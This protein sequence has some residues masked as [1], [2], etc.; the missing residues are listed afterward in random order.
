MLQD[1]LQWRARS[2]SSG[3]RSTRRGLTVNQPRA[4]AF[5]EHL[6]HPRIRRDGC[7]VV[8]M[9]LQSTFRRGPNIE[10]DHEGHEPPDRACPTQSGDDLR[11]S[12][13]VRLAPSPDS[14]SDRGASAHA[15]HLSTIRP[16]L[17]DRDR[18]APR[19]PGRRGGPHRDGVRTL[20]AARHPS[21]EA[22]GGRARGGPDRVE[23][24][25]GCGRPVRRVEPRR[26][27]IAPGRAREVEGGGRLH[28]DGAGGRADRDEGEVRRHPAPRRVG[29]ARPARRQGPGPRQQRHLPDGPVRDPGARFL[30]GR[31]LRRRPG[32]GDLRPVS[33][34]LQ[35]LAPA[36]RV[37]DPTTSPSAAPGSTGRASSWSRR[38]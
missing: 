15:F 25:E 22:A 5:F 12:T 20:E 28:G 18:G 27:E 4:V 2:P 31:H 26:V 8:A 23:A 37:A 19:L 36:R 9:A 38:G 34:P 24:A 11:G 35:R 30:Q 29:R 14:P 21:P 17:R 6:G 16:R 32:G 7:N 33:P 3:S 13:S 1:R 10:A